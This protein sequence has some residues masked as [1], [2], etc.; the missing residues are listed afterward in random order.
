M[1][2]HFQKD[3][4]TNSQGESQQAQEDDLIADKSQIFND[5]KDDT[6]KQQ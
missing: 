5:A 4:V 6:E 2:C 1:E 3:F